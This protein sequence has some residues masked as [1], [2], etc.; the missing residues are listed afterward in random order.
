LKEVRRWNQAKQARAEKWAE[1][2]RLVGRQIN[3]LIQDVGATSSI[4]QP[5]QEA[6]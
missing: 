2:D 4:V 3:E 1:L 5:V 6:R